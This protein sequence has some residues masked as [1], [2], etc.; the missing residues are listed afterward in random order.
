MPARFLSA[1]ILNHSAIVLLSIF[2]EIFVKPTQHDVCALRINNG[3]EP[4]EAIRPTTQSG[5]LRKSIR[6]P[7]HIVAS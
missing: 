4:V 1:T 6:I 5:V 7:G 3:G 2:R